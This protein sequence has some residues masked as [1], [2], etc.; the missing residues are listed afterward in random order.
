M[1]GLYF[2]WITWLGWI[3]TTFFMDK[4][5]K[6]LILSFLILLI[7]SLSS[8]DLLIN[9][10]H[11]NLVHLIILILPFALIVKK[12]IAQKVYLLICSLT[13]TIAYVTFQLFELFDPI[14]LFLDRKWMLAIVLVYLTLMLTKERVSRIACLL[15]G[16][17]QG[18]LLYGFIINKFRFNYEI[19]SYSFLDVLSLSFIIVFVWLKLEVLIQYIDEMVQKNAKGETRINE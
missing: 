8:I 17:C 10:Y 5:K 14:W 11:L 1:E 16:S 6:R 19:G 13:I 18:E 12:T 9:T 3:Y 2:Y 7:L 15:I 4:G